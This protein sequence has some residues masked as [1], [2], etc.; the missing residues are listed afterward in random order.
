MNEHYTYFRKEKLKFLIN[1]KIFVFIQ[2]NLFLNYVFN[3]TVIEYAKIN[4]ANT[5]GNVVVASTFS[6]TYVVTV[7]NLIAEVE[8]TKSGFESTNPDLNTIYF[9]YITT[10]NNS[11]TEVT[12]FSA[13]E[14]L[15]VY[16]QNSSINAVSLTANTGSA[17]SNADTI[18]FG[19]TFGSE[20]TAN[21]S[22]NS[23]G[24]IVGV[25]F[26]NT[27]SYGI[28]YRITDLPTVANIVTSTGSGANLELFTVAL[29]KQDIITIANTSFHD[30][31]GNIEFNSIG[32]AQLFKVDDGIIFQKGHFSQVSSQSIIVS[33]YESTANNKAVGFE[34]TESI[35]NNST[36]ASLNDNASGFSNENAPGAYRLKLTPTLVKYPEV[37]ETLS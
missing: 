6:N 4:D 22:T 5:S 12:A 15:D 11:G 2:I 18:V 23:T 1:K 29:T 24:G 17:Y 36:D 35:A 33:D 25:S 8:N 28:S 20:G 13:G 34:T 7:D 21:L 3:N 31:G 30:A 10:G 9:N 32:S 19:S 26:N 27:A 37:K 16:S 14:T